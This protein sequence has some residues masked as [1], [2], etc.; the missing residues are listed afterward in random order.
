MSNKILSA[1]ITA[2]IAT[3]SVVGAQIEIPKPVGKIIYV[4][5]TERNKNYLVAMNADGSEKLRITPSF[6]NLSFPRYCK[7]NGWI[8]FTSRQPNEKT[9]RFDSEIY[10][11]N[12]NKI[13]KAIT[14]ASLEDFSP[15]GKKLLYISNDGNSEL[16]VYDIAKK[17]KRKISGEYKV[18]SARW[19]ENGEFIAATCLEENHSTDILLISTFSNNIIRLTHSLGFNDAY[20]TFMDD[21]LL[22]FNSDANEK[23]EYMIEFME[24]SRPLIHFKSGHK[25]VFP[26]VAPDKMWLTFEDSGNIMIAYK[27]IYKEKI[28]KGKAPIWI[29]NYE[30]VISSKNKKSPSKK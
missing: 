27:T 16:Y 22:V 24:I 1:L 2:F 17:T 20:P 5:T 11:M 30:P 26:S 3:T 18:L 8:G 14:G 25:G 7:A 10:L 28:A 15:D 21:S 13:R 23:K 6:Y 4:D 19:S 29:E 12:K 9:K